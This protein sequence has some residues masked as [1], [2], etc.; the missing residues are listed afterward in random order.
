M[1]VNL[2]YYLT[3]TLLG[4]LHALEPGHGK[5]VV[6]A[7]LIGS[8]GRKMDAV[9]LGLVVTLT[10]TLS[11]I[12]LAIAAKV[13]STR[14]TLTEEALHGYLGIVAGLMILAVGIWMLVQRIRGREPFH[15]HSHD[16]GHGHSHS[17]D[18]LQSHS[19]PHDHHHEED[20]DHHHYHEGH[21]L[22]IHGD[23]HSH[24][25]D[26]GDHSHGHS[27]DHDHT[28]N[29]AHGHDLLHRHS[30]DDSRGS[31]P[32]DVHHHDHYHEGHEVET[33][34][35][36]HSHDHSHGHSHDHDHTH[37]DESSEGHS[38]PHDHSHEHDGEHNHREGHD[39]ATHS[40]SHT[41]VHPHNHDHGNNPHSVDMREGKR[42]SFWQ[43]FLLG[44]SGGLVPCPAAIA[45]L[46]AA[47]GAGR[48]GE[49]LTY[50]LL[51]SLGLAAVLIAIGIAVVSAG[52]FASR[53]L[54]AKRFARKV[55]IGGAAL[56]TFIGCL[57]LVSSVRHLI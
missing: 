29:H 12:L 31:N 43:L 52:S 15:F 28:Y 45:I 13:A 32:G 20:H 11:V 22:E 50:I 54:D 27:H 26:H 44:V 41:H 25:H 30:H 10:H 38:H 8:K 49:G 35:S 1:Q 37:N 48:L 4:G 57:T 33:D 39:L 5:T 51:F 56:V 3:A 17:H 9:V 42:V 18:P 40:S 23:L 36:V 24:S 46:L 6:A 47:V 16:H 7:Y 2:I 34:D 21:H 14:I 19:H 55:A 53:F